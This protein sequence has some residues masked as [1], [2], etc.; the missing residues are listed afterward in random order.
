MAIPV[1]ISSEVEVEVPFHDID[2][3]KVAWHGHYVKYMEIA[4]TQLTRKFDYDY[5]EMEA[6]GFAWPIVG[7]NIKYSRPAMYGRKLRIVA[8]LIEWE[9]RMRIRYT[10]YDAETGNKLTK[11]ESTQVAVN[12]NTGEMKLG[13]PSILADKLTAAGVN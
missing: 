2:V 13:S 6:S 5:P 8:D 11:A 12:I 10:I 7:I 1:L 9:L 3:M 4:R